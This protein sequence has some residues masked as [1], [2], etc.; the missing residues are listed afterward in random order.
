MAQLTNAMRS[1]NR[2]RKIQSSP[3]RDTRN[4]WQRTEQTGSREKKSHREAG[5][6]VLLILSVSPSPIGSS[7][8]LCL[9]QYRTARSLPRSRSHCGIWHI[10]SVHIPEALGEFGQKGTLSR[11]QA[12]RDE[13][14]Q[15]PLWQRPQVPECIGHTSGAMDKMWH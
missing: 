12:L 10:G 9:P 6:N 5:A 2:T 8:G 7:N 3:T 4:L 14:G 13:S 1:P 15:L 11:A